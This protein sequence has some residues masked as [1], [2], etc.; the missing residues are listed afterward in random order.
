MTVQLEATHCVVRSRISKVSLMESRNATI[1]SVCILRHPGS[2]RIIVVVI[3]SGTASRPF[4]VWI[5]QSRSLVSGRPGFLSHCTA[6]ESRSVH[7]ANVFYP[8]M[9]VIVDFFSRTACVLSSFMIS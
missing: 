1:G 8:F 4:Q 6:R 3:L 9:F 2:F 5:Q 7:S